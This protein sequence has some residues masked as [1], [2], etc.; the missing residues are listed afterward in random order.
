M[1][2]FY[3]TAL[4]SCF[5]VISNVFVSSSIFNN[6]YKKMWEIDK[7]DTLFK[8]CKLSVKRV[9]ALGKKRGYVVWIIYMIGYI[10]V[11]MIDV[12]LI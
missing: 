12:L 3:K 2:F 9:S 4:D 8:D 10:V 1:H 11:Y 6:I 7:K 5:W